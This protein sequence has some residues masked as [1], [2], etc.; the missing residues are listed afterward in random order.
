[1]HELNAEFLHLGAHI[2]INHMQR[3]CIMQE[4]AYSIMHLRATLCHASG[5]TVA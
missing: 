5:Y 1:M 2:I 4:L 3:C